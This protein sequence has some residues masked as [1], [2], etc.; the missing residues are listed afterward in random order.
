MKLILNNEASVQ[1][2][3]IRPDEE[4]L[5]STGRSTQHS[6]IAFMGKKSGYVYIYLYIRFTLL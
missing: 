2:K 1:Y 6:V 3:E 5:Y 4:L